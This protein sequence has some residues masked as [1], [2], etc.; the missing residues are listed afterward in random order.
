VDVRNEY[1]DASDADRAEVVEGQV[2]MLADRGLVLKQWKLEDIGADPARCG[3]AGSPTW[4]R[5]IQAVVLAAQE[6]KRVEPTDE[7]VS[8]LIHELIEDHTIG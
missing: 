2:Q 3:R 7:G 5:R 6:P 8:A 4:V 1:P